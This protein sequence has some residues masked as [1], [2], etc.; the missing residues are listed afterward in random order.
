MNKLRIFTYILVLLVFSTP[1]WAAQ[2]AYSYK[3][4][5]PSLPLRTDTVIPLDSSL[6]RRTLPVPRREL[7]GDSADNQPSRQR[8]APLVVDTLSIDTLF[9]DTLKKKSTLDAVVDYKAKDSIVFTA[10]N[11]GHLYGSSEVYY[12]DLSLKAE[13]IT[14]NVDSSI[15]TAKYGLDSIGEEFGYPVFAEKSGEYESKRMR[16]NFKTK[17]AYIWH[18]ITQQG[19]GY[20][21]AENAKMNP[22]KT[23]FMKDGT[24]TTCDHHDHPHFYVRLTKAKVRPGK[25]VVTGPAYLVIEDL[26]IPFLGIP[27]GFFPITDSYSS[28]VLF[29]SFVDDMDKGF[30]LHDGGYYFAINDHIDLG[31]RG[32]IYTKGSWGLSARSTYKNRYKYNGTFDIGY[33][34]TQLGEKGIDRTVQRDLKLSWTHTQDPKFNMY[35]TFSVKVDYT[36]STYNRNQLN[37]QGTQAYTDNNKSSSITLTQRIPNSPWTFS[38]MINAAQRMKDSTVMLTLP[39]LNI[40]MSRIY[41]FKRKEMMGDERWYEKIYMSYTAD[42]R[43]SITTKEDKLFESDLTKD[44][45]NGMKYSIPIGATF[46]V[47]D[48]LNITPSLNY[49]GRVYT[50]K[51]ERG[52][53]PL[54][55]K[56]GL[57]PKDTISGLYHVYDFNFNLSFQTKLYGM[58]KPLIGGKKI[59]A[60]RHVFTP[61]VTYSYAPN[62][63]SPQWGAYESY[64]YYDGN[65]VLRKEYYSPFE[66]EIFGTAPKGMQ[67]SLNFSFENNL[68]MKWRTSAD[69]LKKISLIDNLGINFNY[70]MAADSMKLSNINTNIRLKLSKSLTINLSGVFDPYL[71][72]PVFDDVGNIKG[73]RKADRLRMSHGKGIGR[74]M[75]TSYSINPNINQDTFK[76]WFGKGDK[77]GTGDSDSPSGLEGE[78]MEGDTDKPKES[79]FA[80]KQDDDGEYDDDGYLKNEVKWSLGIQYGMN[81]GYDQSRIDKDKLEYKRKLRHTFGLNGNIQ[82]TKNWNFSFSLNY[83]FDAKRVAYSSFNLSRNLHCWTIT[84]SF[85]PMG[86]N[87]FFYV[88]ISASSQLLQDLKWEERKRASSIDPIWD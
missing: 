55:S 33:L 72:D 6:L 34:V 65:G 32:E 42:I 80:K 53:D 13:N 2:K 30:G 26:P 69:S 56:T 45:S 10:G 49:N 88:K 59:D 82:P 68:E 14:M 41:P 37:S 1:F 21:V 24:Y 7:S 60:I 8:K 62:F 79:L 38:G 46:S 48:H 12:T 87:K 4:D 61:S 54:Q 25:N 23:F 15:V 43:N 84:S 39:Q 75:S 18:T 36:S 85:S 57:M 71:Y 31:L 9:S 63:A 64:S 20:V 78:S 73:L 22:D 52:Y 51:V 74:L 44:W 35:R 11:I 28:G 86:Q 70:N 19:E 50:R 47:L 5:T 58:Y 81:Y 77:D 16:Y 66:R 29:P 17:K 83:D 27:F 76:K 40:S 3:A 67:S